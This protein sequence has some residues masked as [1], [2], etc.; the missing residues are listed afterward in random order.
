[1]FL[2]VV[3][4]LCY[5][6]A[7]C[8]QTLPVWTAATFASKGV[9]G[10]NSP[11]DVSDQSMSA[12]AASGANV[13][14]YFVDLTPNTG[15]DSNATAYTY[16][17]APLTSVATSAAKYGF[18]VV[19]VLA[20]DDSFETYF[21]GTNS[22]NLQASVSNIWSMIATQFK[23]SNSVAAYDLLNEPIVNSGTDHWISVATN[24][25]KTIRAID[26]GKVIVFEPQPGAQPSAFETLAPLP[27]T[28][29]VYSFHTYSPYQITYQGIPGNGFY[30]QE[31]YPS[32]ATADI[33]AVNSSNLADANNGIVSDMY[34]APVVAFQ[35]KYN[36]PIYVG[37]F[38]CVRWAPIAPTNGL[39]T[40]NNY[41]GDAI[42][43]FES[44]GWAWNY[45]AW[46]QYYG[47]DAELPESLFNQWPYTNA[48]P[49]IPSGLPYS[50]PQNDYA[51]Y[52][53]NTT[54]TM[55]LLK[56]YFSLNLPRP[57]VVI[58]TTNNILT[59][60]GGMPGGNYTWLTSTNVRTSLSSWTT[61][62]VGTFDTNGAF[63]KAIPFTA[64]GLAHFFVLRVP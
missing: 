60:T 8:A 15:N 44:H 38:S 46:R 40:A 6:T 39:P 9:R 21:T 10:F 33:G 22:A 49:V 25:I 4:A 45:H 55:L 30:T 37:E 53:T 32:P 59:G 43:L 23:G 19:V 26:P 29:I 31:T 20:D 48:Y 34:L 36:A 57:P 42:A 27:F 62:S 7:G 47:W 52:R 41:I 51:L 54:D 56:Q 64:S 3:L 24:L 5:T 18:K 28:N 17:L 50:W 13:V 2:M 12:M 16:D 1:M 14:R 35:Q 63:S 61:N 11:G 58:M